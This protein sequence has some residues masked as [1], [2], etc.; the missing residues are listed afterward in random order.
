MNKEKKTKKKKQTPNY[1]K[2]QIARGKMG[3]GMGKIDEG[4]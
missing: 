1:R 2:Q 3:G 4:D